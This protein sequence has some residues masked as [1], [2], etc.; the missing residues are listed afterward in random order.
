MNIKPIK[1][2][3]MVELTVNAN[4]PGQFNFTTQPN[5]RNQPDQVVYIQGIE[6]FP[7]TVYSNSQVSG[8]IAGVA[9]TE[10]PK[11]VLCLYVDQELSMF[12]IPLAKLI[13]VNDTNNPS[14]FTQEITD[15]DNLRDV[16]W[17]KSYV[18][19]SVAPVGAT[20]VIPFG[21]TYIR[22]VRSA[23]DPNKWV[24]G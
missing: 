16:V 23:S 3:E 21:I 4:N 6:V 10:I 13:H 19:F 2:W 24:Q 20:Y 22:E 18:Q 14:I 5:L 1:R 17:E 8:A 11:A 15:F 9:M 12:R 7:D